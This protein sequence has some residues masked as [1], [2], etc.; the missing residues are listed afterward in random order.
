MRA[1]PALG[2][3]DFVEVH[4]RCFAA[5]YRY[6]ASRLGI[7]A[8][9]DV[10]AETFLVAF[11]RREAFDATRGEVRS[12]LFGIATNLISR[13]RRQEARHLRAVQ[14]LEARPVEGHESRVVSSLP[15]PRLAKALARLTRGERD[16]LLLVALAEL[17][18]V[19]VAE[20]LGV[21]TG[22]VG[23]RLSRARKKLAPIL[24]QEAL[25]G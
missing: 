9:E 5:V 11:D 24:A 16:V 3:E 25:D 13:H 23:S 2:T 8:A 6:V 18:Y 15:S 21:P 17:D 20:A 14:R 7:Q 22:T 4:D 19:E 1:A 10:T 12:W